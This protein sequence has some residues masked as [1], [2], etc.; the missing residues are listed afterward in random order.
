MNCGIY[1]ITNIKNGKIYIGSSN[2]FLRRKKDHLWALKA[3]KHHSSKL[4][5]SWNK[6]GEESF[7]FEIV[8]VCSEEERIKREDYYLFWFKP[9]LNI[10]LSA[11]SIM[12]DRNHTQDTKDK[13]SKIKTG[14]PMS[15]DNKLKISKA[16]KGVPKSKEHAAK[17]GLA[18]RGK[19]HGPQSYE[20][21]QKCMK[22]IVVINVDTKEIDVLE[23]YTASYLKYGFI[24]QSVC[25]SIKKRWN[26]NK[27]YRVFLF[28]KFDF[29][30]PIE[31]YI[32]NFEY[33]SKY[34]QTLTEIA[35]EIDKSPTTAYR[36]QQ[37]NIIRELK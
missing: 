30:K 14:I 29:N 17:V 10:A 21:R 5:N 23:S 25:S 19:K 33:N 12:Q 36:M 7:I 24:R 9:E 20:R 1:S 32:Y 37:K 18:S 35:K 31:E 27:K 22:K 16:L 13:I 3:N 11:Y 34:Y 2:D 15:E 28:D 8:E 4:Q 26:I 6:Y